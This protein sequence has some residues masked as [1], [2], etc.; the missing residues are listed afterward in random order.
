MFSKK[1]PTRVAPPNPTID[2]IRRVTGGRVELGDAS[3]PVDQIELVQGAGPYPEHRRVDARGRSDSGR[4][5]VA[6]ADA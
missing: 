1:E 6:V 3:L 2:R 5:A 4:I